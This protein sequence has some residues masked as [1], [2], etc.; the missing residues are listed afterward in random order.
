MLC[1]AEA[2]VGEKEASCGE[3]E[4][5]FEKS[6]YWVDIINRNYNFTAALDECRARG[7]QLASIHS[8]QEQDFIAGDWIFN[9]QF[10]DAWNL[11]KDVG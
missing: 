3:G 11:I 2:I 6:C 7:L 4:T 8:Q 1:K 5:A 9:V 10:L